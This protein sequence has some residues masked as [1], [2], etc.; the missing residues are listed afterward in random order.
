MRVDMIRKLRTAVL[1]II[2]IWA[3]KNPESAAQFVHQFFRTLAVLV[4]AG[5]TGLARWGK[6]G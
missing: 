6:S 5:A 1:V 3:I 2:V 4:R